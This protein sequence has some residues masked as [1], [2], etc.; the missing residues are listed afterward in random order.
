MVTWMEAAPYTKF[1]ANQAKEMWPFLTGF[2]VTG[3]PITYM[4]TKITGGKVQVLW[5]A[6]QAL[7]DV[8]K[9]VL[10]LT[11]AMHYDMHVRVYKRY[12]EMCAPGC[13]RDDRQDAGQS[14]VRV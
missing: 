2:A 8:N 11:I 9:A 5:P 3:I 6:Q 4:A 12:A 14:K 1:I 10:E 13:V 7:T